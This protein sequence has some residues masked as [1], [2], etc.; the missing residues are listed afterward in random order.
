MVT[1]IGTKTDGSAYVLPTPLSLAICREEDTPADSLEVAFP[2]LVSEELTDITVTRDGECIFEG[3]VDEQH[4]C[5]SNGTTTEI[6]SR[7][8]AALLLDNEAQP[9]TLCDPSAEL[10]FRYYAKPVGFESF[11]GEDKHL[12]GEFKVQKGSSCYTALK[13][14]CTK[15]YGK[16]PDVK[17]DT[18]I[19]EDNSQ[20]Q[21]LVLSNSAEGIPYT[22]LRLSTHRYK[23]I[24]DVLAKTES[25]GGYSTAIGNSFAKD[26]RVQRVRYLNATLYSSTPL[27]DAYT[28]IASSNEGYATATVMCPICLVDALGKSL[29]IISEHLKSTDVFSVKEIKYTLSS[30]GESTRLTLR[31]REA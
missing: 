30:E 7:S 4:L 15:V 27:Q 20:K 25:G 29:S 10:M 8:K 17:G 23:L 19:F 3:V 2:S 28:A 31:R 6:I 13:D 1:V 21:P 5:I 24:S 11:W 16:A 9:R 22:N 14:F 26:K 12:Q 18:L